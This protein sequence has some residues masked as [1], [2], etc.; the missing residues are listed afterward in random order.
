MTD[1][2]TIERRQWAGKADAYAGSFAKLCAHTVH[3]LL[4]AAGVGPGVRLLDV[5][6][7]TGTVAATAC[8]RGAVV[9]A[10]DAEPSMVAAASRRAPQADVR[11]ACV[12]DLPFTDAAFDAV[13][14]NFVLNHVGRP[15]AGLAELAR[16]VRPG[17][18]VALSIWESPGGT[19]RDLLPRALREAG[20]RPPGGP[21]RVEPA[22]D[23]PRTAEGFAHLLT[24]AGLADVHCEP[25]AIAHRTTLE[26]WWSGT[27]AGVASTGQLLVRQPPQKA[28]E[29][30][31]HYEALSAEFADADGG[32]VLPHVALVACGR[33]PRQDG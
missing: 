11:L 28:A 8:A 26:E 12:P 7:G 10:V 21:V 1:F 22:E 24:A 4:D 23:F 25:V 14:G 29:V 31:R 17:G 19:G 5:G 32:L 13:T 2:D 27:A 6:T 30:R 9:S 20:V 15:R 16:V 3:H 33:V 18:R